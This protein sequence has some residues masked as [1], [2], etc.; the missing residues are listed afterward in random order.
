M[1]NVEFIKSLSG[2]KQCGE[3]LGSMHQEFIKSYVSMQLDLENLAPN[4]KNAYGGY[5]YVSLDRIL[6]YVK[7]ILKNHGFAIIQLLS[8]NGETVTIHTRLMHVSGYVEESILTLPRIEN[9]KM[10]VVQEMGSAITYGRRYA[11]SAMLGIATDT[12]TDGTTKRDKEKK[13][14]PEIKALKQ[15]IWNCYQQKENDKYLFTQKERDESI[16]KIKSIANNEEALKKFLA[17]LNKELNN[18]RR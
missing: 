4:K 1:E 5:D 16:E 2:V 17:A 7:P 11:I 6:D 15:L 3:I 18:R 12:D 8:G 9:K 13:E 14:R 10:N